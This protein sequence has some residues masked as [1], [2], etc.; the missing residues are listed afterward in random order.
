MV[1]SKPLKNKHS[2]VPVITF[3]FCF[4]LVLSYSLI[5]VLFLNKRLESLEAEP[6][7]EN[8]NYDLLVNFEKSTM[9][10]QI[11]IGSHNHQ[12]TI[13]VSIL[14]GDCDVYITAK[15]RIPSATSWDWRLYH[16]LAQTI[17]IHTYSSDYQNANEGGVVIAV[18]PVDANSQFCKIRYEILTYDNEELLH[19][20]SLRGGKVLMK[21]DLDPSL[22]HKE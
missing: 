8:S 11:C 18:L 2:Q 4:L 19:K 7:V 9:Y 12:H 1:K 22:L 20:L 6:I 15:R 13:K 10:Q 21:R 14:D 16:K 17:S 3:V 5:A